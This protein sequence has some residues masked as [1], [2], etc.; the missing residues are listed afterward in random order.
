MNWKE[1]IKKLKL[2]YIKRTAPDFFEL[3]GGY[4]MKVK[5]YTDQ[6]TNGLTA[7]VYDWLKFSGCY[8]NRINSQG[9]ARVEKVQ[10]AFGRQLEKVKYT[11]STTN[12]GTADLDSIISG[13]PVK[14]EIKCE[15]TKDR[16]REDQYK[17]K[18]RI[19]RAGGVYLVVKNMPQFVEWFKDFTK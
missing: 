12:K 3:S 11:P 8:C 4:K 1:E 2:E 9:Q 14:I 17:E 13:K 15:A 7:A 5:A 19:E 10:L 16:M 6:T 18:E